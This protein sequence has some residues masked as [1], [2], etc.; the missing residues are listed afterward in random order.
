M[1]RESASRHGAVFHSGPDVASIFIKEGSRPSV[2]LASGEI[3]EADVII[4]ADGPDGVART[5]VLDGQ[6]VQD[7]HLGFTI[8][9]SV[10]PCIIIPA[11]DGELYV[12]KE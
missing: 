5:E 6:D 7:T 10:H 9:R 4:A 12:H 3:L 11:A 2:T 8:Y 1:L